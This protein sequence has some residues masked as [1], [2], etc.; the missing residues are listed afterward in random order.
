MKIPFFS[1]GDA[2]FIKIIGEIW[3]KLKSRHRLIRSLVLEKKFIHNKNYKIYWKR[4]ALQWRNPPFSRDIKAFELSKS[5]R[6]R[7]FLLHYQQ[8]GTFT[9]GKRLRLYMEDALIM[10]QSWSTFSWKLPSWIGT[11][12]RFYLDARIF[13]NCRNG[14]RWW[15]LLDY[16]RG[17]SKSARLF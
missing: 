14:L 10:F 8:H 9:L 12:I 15:C 6:S 17:H 1:F 5:T 16:L 13:R 4:M 7:Y 2:M 3:I 11:I